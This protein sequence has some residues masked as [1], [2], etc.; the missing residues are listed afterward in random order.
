MSWKNCLSFSLDTN[1]KHFQHPSNSKGFWRQSESY[2][3]RVRLCTLADGEEEEDVLQI[4]ASQTATRLQWKGRS[5]IWIQEAFSSPWW[6][7][8]VQ[9]S[10]E[11]YGINHDRFLKIPK[12]F[13]HILTSKNKRSI[14]KVPINT[15]TEFAFWQRKVQKDRNDGMHIL[16]WPPIGKNLKCVGGTH[17]EVSQI[18]WYEETRSNG[19]AS[20][21]PNRNTETMSFFPQIGAP[22]RRQIAASFFCTKTHAQTCENVRVQSATEWTAQVNIFHFL[23]SI[24]SHLLW[25]SWG[26]PTTSFNTN[27]CDKVHAYELSVQITIIPKP[28]LRSLLG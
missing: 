27:Y 17:G 24:P 2:L 18:W 20:K 4:A 21:A 10:K 5:R 28:E 19:N 7:H 13:G 26:Y 12:Y 1:V 3:V 8:F 22:E 23:N 15:I 14:Q 9:A 6:Q 25:R 16:Q 11:E